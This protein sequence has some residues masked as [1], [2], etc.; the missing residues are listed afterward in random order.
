[1][2]HVGWWLSGLWSYRRIQLSE[3]GMRT[4]GIIN[5]HDLRVQGWD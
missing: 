1:M 5:A 3:A 4:S 2:R